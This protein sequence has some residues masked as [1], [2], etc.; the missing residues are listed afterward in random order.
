MALRDFEQRESAMTKPLRGKE[1]LIAVVDQITK[2]PETWDQ[3][4]WHCGTSHC[5]A[6]W[7]QIMGGRKE[8]ADTALDD[9]RE[10]IGLADFEANY[11]IYRERT[12]PEIVEFKDAFIN[13]RDIA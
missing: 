5:V 9:A 6:G 4:Q 2:H 10:L 3:T 11:L 12:I 1:L 13:D 8:D 7:A